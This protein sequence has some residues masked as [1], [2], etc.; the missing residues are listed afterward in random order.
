MECEE[1]E[2]YFG[3]QNLKCE[4]T[5]DVKIDIEKIKGFHS[6]MNFKKEEEEF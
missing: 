1:D 3:E 2:M 6:K 4:E 5:N